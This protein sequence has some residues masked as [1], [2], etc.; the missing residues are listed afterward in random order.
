MAQIRR[1]TAQAMSQANLDLV[2][3]CFDC[4]A[5]RDWEGMRQCFDPEVEIIE[6]DNMP[7]ARSYRGY[8][9]LV[10]AY[11][12]WAGQSEAFSVEVERLTDVGERVVVLVR[13][14]GRGRRSGVAVEAT[15]GYVYT[16]RN[17]RFVRWEIFLTEAEALESVRVQD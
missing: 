10:A 15:V 17:D 9:G 8:D 1:D 3:R 4:F 6:P 11:E 2:R 5:S 16:V 12:H 13:H 7:G 14:R